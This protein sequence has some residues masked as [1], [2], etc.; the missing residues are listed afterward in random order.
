LA[1]A[2]LGPKHKYAITFFWKGK[3]W[4]ITWSNTESLA[5]ISS[6]QKRHCVSRQGSWQTLYPTVISFHAV[7]DWQL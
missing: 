3:L 2:E 6:W 7:R 1:L 5:F 4:K